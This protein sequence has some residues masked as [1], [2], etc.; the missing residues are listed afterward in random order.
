MFD[1]E[2]VA[3]SVGERSGLTVIVAVHSTALGQPWAGVACGATRIG[4]TR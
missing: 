4:A 1:H 3:I 2:R